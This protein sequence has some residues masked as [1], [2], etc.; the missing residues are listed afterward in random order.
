ME[1]IKFTFYI[2]YAV[3]VALAC[4]VIGIV[5]GIGQPCVEYV[6]AAVQV[7]GT[8]PAGL[9]ERQHVFTPP[10]GGEPAR[11][12]YYYGPA[13]SDL[14]YVLQV[15]RARWR[16]AANGWEKSVDDL[17]SPVGAPSR[18]T[19][20]IGVGLAAGLIFALPFGAL[21]AAAVWLTHEIVVDIATVGVQAAAKIL[22]AVDS[23]ILSVRHIQVRCVACFE[24]IPYP[25][26]LCQNPSC[27]NTH[28]DIRPGRYGVLRRSCNC[29][30][31]MP[32]V[33]LLGTARKLEAVCP[34]RACHHPLEYRP[35]EVQ[36][37]ILPFSAPEGQARR[38]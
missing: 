30:A 34:H 14:R 13:R 26:Y 2:I 3:T 7:L 37:I 25:A 17:L 22:L 10:E 11:P 20:P 8:R 4:S 9:P 12:N 19:A 24:R 27:D 15:A 31:R 5:A 1:S 33:L 23:V 18:A 29:G 28:W 38:C 16:R 35:G 36:E 32:T 21:L 6:I